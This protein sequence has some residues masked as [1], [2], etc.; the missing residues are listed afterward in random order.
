MSSQCLHLVNRYVAG[1][2][3]LYTFPVYLR[4]IVMERHDMER[5]WFG[6]LVFYLLRLYIKRKKK[7][8]KKKE[9]S[10]SSNHFLV[11]TGSQ[12]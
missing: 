2:R 4:I 9:V 11:L 12:I 8:K 1:H 7:E 6:K 5:L 3:G 10:L